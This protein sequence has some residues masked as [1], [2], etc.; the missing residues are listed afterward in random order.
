MNNIKTHLEIFTVVFKALKKNEIKKE[1][2]MIFLTSFTL[3][4]SLLGNTKT[5]IVISFFSALFILMV[6][7]TIKYCNYR[8]LGKIIRDGTTKIEIIFGNIENEKEGLILVPCES[9]FQS[10]DLMIISKYSLQY[11]YL[12]DIS[13][14]PT[15][16]DSIRGMDYFKI[17]EDADVYAFSIVQLDEDNIAKFT[18]E[19]Y[20]QL[21]FNMCR[22]IDKI[23]KK[24]Q[25][26]IPIVG[27]GVKI[28]DKDMD[29]FDCLSL[30]IIIFK[31]YGFNRETSIKIVVN[32]N[33]HS[34]NDINLFLFD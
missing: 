20:I 33:K 5:M 11:S 1:F 24:K 14:I 21:I 17:K 10:K 6:I 2:F 28:V 26:I 9:S 13:K 25:I 16:K 30:I 7:I 19:E 31:L 8:K 34:M 23:S 15:N 18:I 3:G 32:E 4:L 12:K 29:S 27:S 22:L